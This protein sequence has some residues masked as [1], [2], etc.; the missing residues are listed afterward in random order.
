[1]SRYTNLY[2]MAFHNI[3]VRNIVRTTEAVIELCICV[4]ENIF[5]NACWEH[6]SATHT[7]QGV[8]LLE[9]I[10]VAVSMCILV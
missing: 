4:Y 2:P 6:V 8:Q 7:V 3:D 1:M 5:S 9:K 10:R